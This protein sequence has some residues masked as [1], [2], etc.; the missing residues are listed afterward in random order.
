MTRYANQ[1]NTHT[2]NMLSSNQGMLQGCGGCTGKG[3]GVVQARGIVGRQ[4][5]GKKPV[6]ATSILYMLFF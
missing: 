3:D 1:H 6:F 2:G 4:K 5:G